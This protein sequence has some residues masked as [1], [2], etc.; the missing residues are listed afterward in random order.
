MPEISRFFGIIIR[1]YYND[2]T[3]PH[4]HAEYQGEK[5][6]LDFRGNIVRGGIGSRTALRLVREWID[7]HGTELEEDWSLARAGR[8]LKPVEPLK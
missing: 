3:P 5:V 2:H 4:V 6:L 8:E 1:M 7:L